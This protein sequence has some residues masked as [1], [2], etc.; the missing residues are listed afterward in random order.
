VGKV[1]VDGDVEGVGFRVAIGEGEGL[2]V[3]DGEGV[4]VGRP[5]PLI[6]AA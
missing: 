5:T 3:G 1:E 4:A 2:A 6:R